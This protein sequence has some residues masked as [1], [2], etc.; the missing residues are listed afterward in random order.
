M[1]D[2]KKVRITALAFLVILYFVFRLP[3]LGFDISNTDAIR[4]HNRSENF[5]QALKVGDF[6]STYQ[7]YQP[8]VTLMWLN[9]FVKQ[10][11]FTYQYSILGNPAPNTLENADFYPI[12]HGYSKLMILL[13]LSGLLTFQFLALEKLFNFK[14]AVIFVVLTSLEPYLIGMDRWFHLTS[15]E[16]YFAFSSLL[17]IM[18]WKKNSQRKYLIFSAILFAFSVL[19]KL[20]TLVTIP[21]Y[22]IIF[23]KK[24]VKPIFLFSAISFITFALCFPAFIVDPIYVLTKLF[25]AATAAVNENYRN[26]LLTPFNS[27]FFYDLV[28][29]LKLSPITV[30]LFILGIFKTKNPIFLINILVYYIFLSISDQKIDRY[31]LAMFPSI[32]LIC[33][34]YI[35]SLKLSTQKLIILSTFVFTIS[36]SYI[37]Y[38][39]YSAYY[40]PILGGTSGALKLKLYDNSG[41]YFAQAAFYLNQKGRK[42]KTYVP[43]G[44]ASLDPFYKG[45]YSQNIEE[46]DYLVSSLDLTRLS[47]ENLSCKTPDKN[48]GS[49]EK[50]VVFVFKCNNE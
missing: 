38:P 35:N 19:S 37:Y 27:I 18:L 26:D 5:L 30:L 41:E 23:F 33:A 25:S 16:T 14:I 8:G 47:P 46:S 13:V 32:L 28:L 44:F 34:T 4:W 17:S 48:F 36:M 11:S 45:E 31:S 49:N 29:L 9:A 15:L 20:T 1:L 10:A 2:S 3:G 40:S 50:V 42:I 7:H 6:K 21:V 22:L 39:V 12:I 24:P 43:N